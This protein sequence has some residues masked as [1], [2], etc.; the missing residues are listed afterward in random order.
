MWKF[1]C[2]LSIIWV[3]GN[4]A[5]VENNKGRQVLNDLTAQINEMVEK[6]LRDQTKFW[7]RSDE[8]FL[9][10][11]N[12]VE[13]PKIGANDGTCTW[14]WDSWVGREYCEKTLRLVSKQTKNYNN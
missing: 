2:I 8:R 10:S 12:A 14:K 11:E 5:P 7:F 3:V 6:G 4:T 1:A 9:F 13:V